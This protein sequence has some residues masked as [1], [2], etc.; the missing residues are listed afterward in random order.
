[1][2]VVLV[3]QNSVRMLDDAV[4]HHHLERLVVIVQIN[5]CKPLQFVL[6]AYVYNINL[7]AFYNLLHAVTRVSY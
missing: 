1:M 5:L 7:F 2:S 6:Y 4:P 3:I